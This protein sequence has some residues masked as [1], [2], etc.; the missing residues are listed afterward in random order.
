MR[1][2]EP[3]YKVATK[4]QIKFLIWI[5]VPL[6]MTVPSTGSQVSQAFLTSLAE[7]VVY[8]P[9]GVVICSHLC[10]KHV[11]SAVLYQY[12]LDIHLFK[13]AA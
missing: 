9:L 4:D 10:M 8:K 13:S 12:G 11:Y 5:D 2:V 7:H 3:V 1:S 6:C